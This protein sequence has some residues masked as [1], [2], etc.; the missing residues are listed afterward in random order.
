[1]K[2]KSLFN[3]EIPSNKYDSGFIHCSRQLGGCG[4]W[5]EFEIGN[6]FNNYEIE[7]F[8]LSWASR[9]GECDK[10]EEWLEDEAREEWRDEIKDEYLKIIGEQET[11]E[12]K[13]E[14]QRL[15]R[16]GVSIRETQW[17]KEWGAVRAVGFWKGR[18]AGIFICGNCS[19]E[20]K[21]AGKHGQA[22]NRNNPAFW[23]LETREKV[24]CG[25]CLEKRK[26]EMPVIRR[27]K[28]NQY[29]KLEMFRKS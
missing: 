7:E 11:E 6:E 12:K 3:W 22:K 20:I 21:G 8:N 5:H 28:F 1:M 16:E 9:E 4:K 23:G 27:M 26:G 18:E 10:F 14:Q 19:Q 24:L 2:I 29:V 25:K 17:E 13:L 15:A